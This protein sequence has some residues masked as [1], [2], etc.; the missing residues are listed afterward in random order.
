MVCKCTVMLQLQTPET[1]HWPKT[2]SSKRQ[3]DQKGVIAI[4]DVTKK[5]PRWLMEKEKSSEDQ[6]NFIGFVYKWSPLTFISISKV[7]VFG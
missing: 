7:A 1:P 2:Y 6:H 3:E 4:H 5:E